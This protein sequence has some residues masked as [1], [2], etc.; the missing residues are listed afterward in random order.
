MSSENSDGQ[1]LSYEPGFIHHSG[2]IIMFLTIVP[3]ILHIKA[4]MPASGQQKC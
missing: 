2:K 4:V 3:T 1:S